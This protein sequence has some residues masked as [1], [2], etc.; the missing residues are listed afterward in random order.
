APPSSLC[1]SHQPA[2]P[3]LYTLSLHDAL[4]IFPLP[5]IGT[6]C[7]GSTGAARHRIRAPVEGCG[8]LGHRHFRLRE[9]RQGFRP[10]LMTHSKSGRNIPRGETHSSPL[11]P[12]DHI[13]LNLLSHRENQCRSASSAPLIEDLSTARQ[14]R[15]GATGG[16]QPP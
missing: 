2:P 1:S 7:R 11:I 12:N 13:P 5:D 9:V 4:P 14:R 3:Q 8:A 6:R 10:S 15:A 16:S